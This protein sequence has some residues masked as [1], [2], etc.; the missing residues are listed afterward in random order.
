MRNFISKVFIFIA[1]LII[2][3]SVVSCSRAPIVRVH[4]VQLSIRHE[5]LNN[6]S[7]DS[8]I[9]SSY[10]LSTTFCQNGDE[11]VVGYNFMTSSLD[12]I[13]LSEETYNYIKIYQDGPDAIQC[14]PSSLYPISLDS[15][16]IYGENRFY[17]INNKGAILKKIYVPGEVLVERNYAMRIANFSYNKKFGYLIYPCTENGKNY[18]NILDVKRNKLKRHIEL[19]FPSSNE[20]GNHNYA[21][22]TYPNVSYHDNIVLYNYPYDESIFT[23]NIKTLKQKAYM[24]YTSFF[25]KKIRRYTG[26]ER[27]KDWFFYGLS[28]YHFYNLVFIK[29]YNVY[30]RICLSGSKIEDNYNPFDIINKKRLWVTFFSQDLKVLGESE[31]PMLSHSHF[32]GWC[33]A[34]DGLLFYNCRLF[35]SDV[36]V[37]S[38]LFDRLQPQL[39]RSLNQTSNARR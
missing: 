6:I 38:I 7:K 11:Y 9:L 10:Y 4:R 8:L 13:N 22:L 19:L 3:L 17:L 39:V 18:I 26:S 37:R 23:L 33:L 24:G 2:M 34:N 20:N 35:P 30:A 32:T 31:I 27:Y 5:T 14:K 25:P 16:W 1:P 28:N 36:P 12:V 15:I 29:K 21:D